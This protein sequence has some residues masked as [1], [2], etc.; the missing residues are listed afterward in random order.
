MFMADK[1]IIHESASLIRA[2]SATYRLM[3]EVTCWK[4]RLPRQKSPLAGDL[5]F[6]EQLTIFFLDPFY[7]LT[8][9]YRVY[10]ITDC[11]PVVLVIFHFH[12]N[13]VWEFG[14][15]FTHNRHRIIIGDLKMFFEIAG[16]RP[17]SRVVYEAAGLFLRVVPG[18]YSPNRFCFF[19][20]IGVAGHGNFK[21]VIIYP[22]RNVQAR[23]G[24]GPFGR[25]AGQNACN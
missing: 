1:I 22:Y 11:A 16:G 14:R 8:K 23:R 21:H 12:D 10:A 25:P 17:E 3:S 19:S 2:G 7:C 13:A 4:N 20:G 6:T 18:L 15:S 5:K 9:F 24:V